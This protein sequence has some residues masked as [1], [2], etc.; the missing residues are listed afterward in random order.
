[1]KM[2]GELLTCRDF[3]IRETLRMLHIEICCSTSVWYSKKKFE[4]VVSWYSIAACWLAI[5]PSF[6][7]PTL[8]F[9]LHTDSSCLSSYFEHMIVIT[10]RFSSYGRITCSISSQLQIKRGR[11]MYSCSEIAAQRTDEAGRTWTGT[12]TPQR[13]RGREEAGEEALSTSNQRMTRFSTK[14]G[15]KRERQQS[16]T[17]GEE[18]PH[19]ATMLLRLSTGRSS[20]CAP[21][22]RRGELSTKRI[23][24]V[25]KRINEKEI[26]YNGRKWGASANC[27]HMQ[28]LRMLGISWH[29]QS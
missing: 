26:I 23:F 13:R 12:T 14:A 7:G 5:V 20:I 3:H 24:L 19:A 22:G 27:M 29:W 15:E 6:F 9:Q 10:S 2:A 16:A 4:A 18:P 25:K 8:W 1:M 21:L 17:S 11:K 28:H